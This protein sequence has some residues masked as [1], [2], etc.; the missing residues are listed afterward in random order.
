MWAGVSL[1]PVQMWQGRA[2]SRCRCGR[3][4]PSP[5]ADVAGVSPVPVQMWQRLRRLGSPADYVF[6]PHAPLRT[7]SEPFTPAARRTTCAHATCNVHTHART[8]SCPSQLEL[9]FEL[10]DF[11]AG[12]SAIEV[13]ACV[14]REA[15]ERHVLLAQHDGH[16][17]IGRER[18]APVV[19]G[20]VPSHQL[21]L[22]TLRLL[23]L[24]RWI[25]L[26]Q[27]A[28]GTSGKPCPLVTE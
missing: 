2:Q 20:A 11:R 27:P 1:V 12:P 16:L 17:H 25:E 14:S 9:A 18:H 15:V 8:P 6:D 4:E 28:V 10:V 19:V 5:G 21:E 26:R 13:Q 22:G 3:G 7:C 24:A 23:D